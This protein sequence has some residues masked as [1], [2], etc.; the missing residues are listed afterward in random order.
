MKLRYVFALL[1]LAVLHCTGVSA[2]AIDDGLYAI[3]DSGPIVRTVDGREIHLAE[4][5][6]EKGI[7]VLWLR[8]E[9]NDNS[10]FT[11]SLAKDGV[12]SIAFNRMA[13]CVAEHCIA[14]SGS[15]RNGDREV[16]ID[17]WFN[18]LAAANAYAKFFGTTVM[19][20]AHPGHMLVTRFVP[21]KTTS[22]K[23][24]VIPVTLEIKNVGTAE[25]TFQVGGANRGARDN[26]FGFTAYGLKAVPD[27]GDP[28]NFGGLSYNHTLKSGQ[29]FT[30]DVDLRK[31]FTFTEPG[32]YILTGTYQLTFFDPGIRDHFVVW[33]DYATA[34]FLITV[35]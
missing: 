16:S 15:G 31:W 3:G 9:S 22:S 27:T 32:L 13:L 34:R 14:F 24:E 19:M 35:K 6:D 5:L 8:S 2:A 7:R 18:S 1:I 25:V 4:K 21:A 26:Q 29:T 12:F 11:L 28:S 20:R 10:T 23:D 33:D 30:K 17:A